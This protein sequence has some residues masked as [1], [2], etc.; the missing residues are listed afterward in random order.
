MIRIVPAVAIIL[1]AIGCAPDVEV[2]PTAAGVQEFRDTVEAYD[3][4]RDRERDA[5]AGLSDSAPARAIAQHASALQERI[6]AARASARQGDVFVTAVAPLFR[7]SLQ[8][9]FDRASRQN[10]R[11][12]FDQVPSFDVT[13]NEPYPPSVPVGRFPPTLLRRLPQLPDGLAYRMVGPHLV[14]RDNEANLIVDF[15]PDV[16]PQYDAR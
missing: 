4:L 3:D 6:R 16:L 2:N 5:P 10:R 1:A 7:R 9:Y 15:L 13:V 14:L 8:Q 12:M 11:L